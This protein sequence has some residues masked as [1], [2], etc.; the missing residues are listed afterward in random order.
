MCWRRRRVEPDGKPRQLVLRDGLL[1]RH[2]VLAE[3]GLL[4]DEHQQRTAVVQV[5]ELELLDAG[6]RRSRRGRDGDVEHGVREHG[7]GAARPALGVASLRLDGVAHERFEA[8]RWTRSW[9]H[10]LDVEAVGRIG[11]HA[12]GGRV[13][14]RDVAELLELG[15]VVADRGGADA[16]AVALGDLLGRHGNRRLDVVPDDEL[17]ETLAAIVELC[18]RGGHAKALWALAVGAVKC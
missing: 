9:G 4:H 13:G 7:G 8:A 2:D 11:G 15:H 17:E 18:G 6:V 12:A 10:A 14:P 3:A 5:D 16:E 1:E